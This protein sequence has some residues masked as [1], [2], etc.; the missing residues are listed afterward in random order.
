[1]AL[2]LRNKSFCSQ[3]LPTDKE[4]KMASSTMKAF[5]RAGIKDVR[6]NQFSLHIRDLKYYYEH[7]NLKKAHISGY[8]N[9]QKDYIIM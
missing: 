8:S 1:M 7:L 5:L 3:E 9:L 6:G 2:C 4:K